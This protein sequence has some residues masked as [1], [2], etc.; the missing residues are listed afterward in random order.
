MFKDFDTKWDDVLLP[1]REAPKDEILESKNKTK[2]TDSEQL[3]TTFDLYNQDTALKNEPTSH[4]HWK[5]MSKGT[6]IRQRK[7]DISMPATT[8]SRVERPSD[9]KPRREA[10]RRR[11]NMRLPMKGQRKVL[12]GSVMRFQT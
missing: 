12:Q 1:F 11:E 6:W 2:L 8:E 7:I 3:K 4:T 10:K 5:N 9:G